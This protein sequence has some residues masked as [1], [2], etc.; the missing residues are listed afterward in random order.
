[1]L[2]CHFGTSNRGGLFNKI[3]KK[4]I[5]GFFMVSNWHLKERRVFQF[6]IAFCDFKLFDVPFWHIKRLLSLLLKA[7]LQAIYLHI[8][9]LAKGVTLAPRLI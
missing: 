4:R 9:I 8:V 1:V 5:S 3:D 2:I 7:M 6:D